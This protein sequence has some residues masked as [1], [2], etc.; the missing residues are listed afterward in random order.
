MSDA[1]RS[2]N[3]PESS[4]K[5]EDLTAQKNG[6]LIQDKRPIT[7]T[8]AY[9][10]AEPSSTPRQDTV[11][12]GGNAGGC[13]PSV[14]PNAPGGTPTG[15]AI[16]PGKLWH[17]D[18]ELNGNVKSYFP[19]QGCEPTEKA[20]IVALRPNQPPLK[21]QANNPAEFTPHLT[22]TSLAWVNCRVKDLETDA[23]GVAVSLGFSSSIV[24]ALLKN[25]HS[26]YEDLED[27]LGM[28]LPAVRVDKL[29]VHGFK[30]L[31]LMRDGLIFTIHAS[32]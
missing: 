21:L 9:A 18:T 23:A 15:G 28:M 1:D 11:D 4:K 17:P 27:Q 32:A 26:G 16:T 2:T 13:A 8:E 7:P 31:I 29:T 3:K 22:A 6:Q 19:E 20:F 10:K 30:Y 25:R 12:A 14:P 5:Q 24:E